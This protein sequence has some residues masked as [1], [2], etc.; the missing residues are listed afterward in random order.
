MTDGWSWI[1]G[2]FAGLFRAHWAL[3][4]FRHWQSERQTTLNSDE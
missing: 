4:S 2:G 1:A 3:Q